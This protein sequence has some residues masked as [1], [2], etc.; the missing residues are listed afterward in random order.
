[1]SVSV[2]LPIVD[3]VTIPENV[4]FPFADIVAAVPT[5]TPPVNV[6]TPEAE[7]PATVVIPPDTKF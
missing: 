7:N 3:T 1:M 2:A 4:A 6:E 5:F